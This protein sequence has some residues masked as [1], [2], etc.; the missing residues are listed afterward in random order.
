MQGPKGGQAQVQSR[1]LARTSD[2]S[3][4]C[5]F[6]SFLLL[7]IQ[8]N[9]N[10]MVIV[11][12]YW[13]LTVSKIML[14]VLHRFPYLTY[15][16]R[17]GTCYYHLNFSD[18]ENEAQRVSNLSSITPSAGDGTGFTVTLLA[19]ASV[20]QLVGHHPTNQR[21][22]V[23]FRSWH[24][25]GLWVQS[26]VGAHTRDSQLMFLFLSSFPFPLSKIKNKIF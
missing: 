19:L 4:S 25:P 23:Q 8:K 15:R 11:N 5:S 9:K 22:T 7:K 2:S 24:M 6:R 13:T 3:R 17:W 12:I 21:V 16:I 20:A 1:R 14:S 18:K 26:P 10:S